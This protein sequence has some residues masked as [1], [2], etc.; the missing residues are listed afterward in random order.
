M[1]FNQSSH[2]FILGCERSGSTWL[3]NVLDACADIE[4]FMEPFAD[5]AEL[6]PGFPNR[7]LSI[8]HHSDALANVLSKGY[9]NLTKKKY[10]LFYKR[11]KNL[12][13]KKVDRLVI[14][15][16]ARIGRWQKL[17]TPLQVKQFQLLNLN[18]AKVPVNWH[19]KKN[20]A[21]EMIVTKELRL[22]LKLGLLQ[23][24]FPQAKYI[25]IVRHPGAQIASILKLFERGS[26]GELRRSLLS[27]YPYLHAYAPS[28]FEKYSRHYKQLDKTDGMH[29]ILL[30]WWL[31][32]Y[33][34]LIED[35]KLYGVNYRV[36]Y[37]E[38][39]SESPME[40]YRKL[41]SYLGLNFSNA[42][43]AY[44]TLSSNGLSS[45]NIDATRISP[46]NTVRDSSKYVKESISNL[47]EKMK[48]GISKLFK[49][50]NVID[51]LR[52]YQ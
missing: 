33:E 14:N 4:F 51:E 45:K 20:K 7:N 18:L 12:Y 30:L 23:S 34:T 31:I 39:L 38:D 27:L 50:F 8:G 21:P 44:I 3:S 37:H 29:E 11:D 41:F 43:K 25:I 35:C 5:Y 6:F 15:L 36:V 19:V 48:I 28:R 10:P 26:L 24:V 22:N 47:D 40:E 52:H 32:N 1:N 16:F 9:E 17:S 46:V 2:A 42:V 49:N 13:W